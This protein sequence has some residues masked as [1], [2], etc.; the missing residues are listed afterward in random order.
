MLLCDLCPW[1]VYLRVDVDRADI[2]ADGR[3]ARAARGVDATR[4]A[5]AVHYRQH[6]STNTA[7]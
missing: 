4:L 7:I 6:E 1:P 3:V 5:V 2:T